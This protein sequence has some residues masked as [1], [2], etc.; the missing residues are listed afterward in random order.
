MLGWLRFH[1]IS[2]TGFSFVR[3]TLLF[4][5]RVFL[6]NN[7][8]NYHIYSVDLINIK[9]ISISL[10]RLVLHM[11]NCFIYHVKSSPGHW[12]VSPLQLQSRPFFLIFFWCCCWTFDASHSANNDP[13]FE[14]LNLQWLNRV[15]RLEMWSWWL[16]GA[17]HTV[18]R[19]QI[20][21]SLSS[22]QL[23]SQLVDLFSATSH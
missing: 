19:S 3:L 2:I 1:I 6:L 4:L 5:G 22:T 15:T 20:L 10:L 14:Q 12:R 8:R 17:Q 18:V 16:G 7:S 13:K 11:I 9:T 21:T 23:S